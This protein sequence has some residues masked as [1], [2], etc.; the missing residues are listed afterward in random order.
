MDIIIDILFIMLDIILDIIFEIIKISPFLFILFIG[1]FLL[2]KYIVLI[3]LKITWHKLIE[4]IAWIGLGFVIGSVFRYANT[5]FY[6]VLIKNVFEHAVEMAI[7]ALI[8]PG[9]FS[10]LALLIWFIS[11]VFI[12]SS[13][14][15]EKVR[16]ILYAIVIGIFT[17]YAIVQAL[18]FDAIASSALP[19]GEILILVILFGGPAFF[20]VFVL[21]L[22]GTILVNR[23]IHKKNIINL[24][25][26]LLIGFTIGFTIGHYLVFLILGLI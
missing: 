26:A 14:I 12:K 16:Y 1:Y 22:V 17:G 3:N 7:Y 4:F 10:I 9:N 11:S 25:F 23:F 15:K 19:R 2:K 6:G 18:I 5:I 21:T 20:G 13:T 24:A 8:I